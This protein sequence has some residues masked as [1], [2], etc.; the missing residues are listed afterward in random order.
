MTG[1]NSQLVELSKI[2]NDTERQILILRYGRAWSCG[3][4]QQQTGEILGLSPQEV[5]AKET[6]ALLKMRV[7]AKQLGIDPSDYLPD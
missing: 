5:S 1:S 6:S 2:L 3:F 4:T 7:R